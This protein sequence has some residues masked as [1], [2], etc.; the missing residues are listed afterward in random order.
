MPCSELAEPVILLNYIQVLTWMRALY[1]VYKVRV[2]GG[3]AI[4]AGVT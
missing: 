2:K 3:H 1:T 4:I